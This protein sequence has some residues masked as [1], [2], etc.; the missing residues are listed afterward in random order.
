MKRAPFPPLTAGGESL[1]D[2][3]APP[4]ALR[5]RMARVYGVEPACVLVVRDAP[6]GLDLLRHIAPRSIC[7]ESP[8]DIA[9]LSQGSAQQLSQTEPLLIVDES[10]IEFCEA[11]ASLA[12]FAAEAQNVAVLRS[13]SYAYGLMGAPCGAIVANPALIAQL[14]AICERAPLATPVAQLALAALDPSRQAL[15]RERAT[16]VRS[17]A[18][19]ISAALRQSPNLDEVRAAA[20]PYVLIRPRDATEAARAIAVFDLDAEARADDTIRIAISSPERNQRILAAF[21]VEIVAQSARRAEIVR[22]TKETRIVVAL[23]LDREAA[24]RVDTGLGFFDHMLAQVA[25]HGGFSLSLSCSGDLEVDAHHTIEDCAL[26]LGQALDKALGERRGLARFGFLLPMDET[27]AQVSVDLGGRPFCVFDGA[28]SAP[29]LGAY[30]TEMTAHVFR[31]LSESMRAAIHVSVE[32]SNDHH[33]TE[34]CFKALGRA[35]RQALRVEGQGLPST[36]GV[37]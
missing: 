21:G 18:Q 37:L 12:N 28:F 17:E 1:T 22:E 9:V 27:E 7:V 29:T 10:L 23:D 32:G 16:L 13:L 8:S 25:L 6:H 31:S 34:A 15:T 26:A 30:P 2:S 14:E 11:T 19:R 5:Q 3:P 24:P 20:G 36:K 4:H 35:L 33:K